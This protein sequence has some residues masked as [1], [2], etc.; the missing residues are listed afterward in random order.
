MTG[1]LRTQFVVD[2]S[3]IAELLRRS[4]KGR[5]VARLIRGGTLAAPAHLDAEV[6]SALA[7]MARENP[8][9]EPLVEARLANLTRAPITRYPCRALL[10]AAWRLRTDV[11]VRDALYVALA[12]RLGAELVTGDRRLAGVPPAVLGVPVHLIQ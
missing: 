3:S 5:R 2:A 8:H 7:R 6:L 1:T 9:E 12:R 11:S 4:R 10:T